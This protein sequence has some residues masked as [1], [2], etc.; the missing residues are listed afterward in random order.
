MVSSH[1]TIQQSA[2]L[3]E[4]LMSTQLFTVKENDLAALASYVMQWK[5]IHH[6]PVENNK[7][8]LCGL[9]THTH[10][11]DYK[12]LIEQKNISVK[13]IM[14]RE[15]VTVHPE[16]TLIDAIRIMKTN[17]FGGLPV[18]YKKQLIGIITLNDLEKW[19]LP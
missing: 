12:Y 2:K 7:G 11:K 10:M 8:Q 17:Q 19:K 14:I 5:N 18:V 4:H 9:L 1:T 13:E 6:L 15:V 16:T 3:V